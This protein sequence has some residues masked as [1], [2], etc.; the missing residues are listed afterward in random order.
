MDKSDQMAQW[1]GR[2]EALIFKASLQTR[3]DQM[4]AALSLLDPLSRASEILRFQGEIRLMKALLS[5]EYERELRV[6]GA[7]KEAIT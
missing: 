5:K 3:L 4:Q 7:H 1:W 2:P 6:L